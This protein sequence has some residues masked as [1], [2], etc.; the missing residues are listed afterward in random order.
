MCERSNNPQWNES[1]YFLVRDPKHQ[2][3]VI[4]VSLCFLSLVDWSLLYL[5][6]HK[7]FAHSQQHYWVQ[8][9]LSL[10]MQLSSGWDEPMGSLVLPVKEL[11]AEPQ[12]V[13]D[14]WLRLDG[15]SAQ[16]QI[17]LRAELKVGKQ[18]HAYFCTNEQTLHRCSCDLF[19]TDSEFQDG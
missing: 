3:L 8:F 19:P 5:W 18:T 11:F 9:S 4:K 7:A 2:M 17:L 13:K 15:A 14:Q 6:L 1:F 16:S 10:P 12:L